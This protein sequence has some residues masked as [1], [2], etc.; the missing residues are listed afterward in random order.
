MNRKLLKLLNLLQNVGH[1]L[2]KSVLNVLVYYNPVLTQASLE[3]LVKQ[4]LVV[5]F[6]LSLVLTL[7]ST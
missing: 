5:V 6:P 7:A 3:A 1:K 4:G 2:E